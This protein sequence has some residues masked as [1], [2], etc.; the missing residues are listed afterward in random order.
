MKL[1]IYLVALALCAVAS[2]DQVP[3]SWK[4]RY[5][6]ECKAITTRNL[7]AYKAYLAKDFV[8][9]TADG[10][11]K[12]YKQTVA[13]LEDVF[14][15][16]SITGYSKPTKVVEHK[17]F[18]EVTYQQEFKFDLGNGVKFDYYGEG[19]DTWKKVGTRWQII[20]TVEKVSKHTPIKK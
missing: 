7:K 5:E 11:K 20:K 15:A 13:E 4:K 6:A 3:N 16:K 1:L 2:G 10:Q 19:V 9:F 18:V 14:K 17:D 8:W 12:T